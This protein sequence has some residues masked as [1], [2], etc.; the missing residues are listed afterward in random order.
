MMLVLGPLARLRSVRLPGEV[1]EAPECRM[2]VSPS[3]GVDKLLSTI[4][5]IWMGGIS[6]RPQHNYHNRDPYVHP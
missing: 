5:G 4:N 1:V 2:E 6:V 3:S